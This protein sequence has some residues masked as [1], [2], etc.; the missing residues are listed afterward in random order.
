MPV[1]E[2]SAYN[3]TVQTQPTEQ[4]CTVTNGSGTMGASNVTNVN[5]S[6][7]TNNTTITVSSTGVIPVNG[8]S[9]SIIVTNTGA[10]F[11]AYN[12]SATLPGGWAGV[13]QDATDC[14]TI[15]PNGGTCTLTF[16]S[17][18]P[19][20]GQG[21]LTVTGDNIT[22]PPTTALAFAIDG[23][24]V[25]SVSGTSPAA[26]ALVLANSDTSTHIWSSGYFDIPGIT[27][28]STAPPCN[29]ATDGSCDTEQIVAVYATPYAYYAAGSCYGITSDNSGTVT[30][31]TWHLPAVCQLGGAGQGAGCPTGLANIDTNLVQLGFTGL[32]DFYWSSTE[33][34][35]SSFDNAYVEAFQPAGGSYQFTGPKD[36]SFQVRC[37]RA[38]TY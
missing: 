33:I 20:V 27:E 4:T 3:V 17:T 12:V 23:Y 8:G 2:G 26:T 38:F 32:N 37:A 30:V 34:A 13:T 31:G 35:I 24:L 36:N 18:T 10:T 25:W 28:T 11:A 7:T 9:G 16:T 6:C 29:G 22:S 5:V 15:S 14:A 19:Y 21:S 1:A